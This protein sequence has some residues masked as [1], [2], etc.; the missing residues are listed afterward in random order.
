MRRV[1]LHH[2]RVIRC[3]CTVA[4]QYAIALDLID[5]FGAPSKGAVDVVKRG[6]YACDAMGRMVAKD[7]LHLRT[8]QCLT[9]VL[10]HVA[11]DQCATQTLSASFTWYTH[12]TLPH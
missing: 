2:A 9:T 7:L 5:V 1:R 3:N 10:D 6:V 8:R 11:G 4:V 12:S